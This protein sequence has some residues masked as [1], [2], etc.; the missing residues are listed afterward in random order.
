[1]NIGEALENG[2]FARDIAP[3]EQRVESGTLEMKA[4]A[5]RTEEEARAQYE[6]L[7]ES[8]KF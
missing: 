6:E 5:D 2:D 4:K 1:M 8:N 3:Y 7:R